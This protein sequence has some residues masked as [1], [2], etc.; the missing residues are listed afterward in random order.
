MNVCAC[1]SKDGTFLRDQ[2]IVSMR[3]IPQYVRWLQ[4]L[5]IQ[6]SI[7]TGVFC[8]TFTFSEDRAVF[9]VSSGNIS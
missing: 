3:Y 8:E 7:I 4:E 6:V 2:G 1:G 9:G 5:F